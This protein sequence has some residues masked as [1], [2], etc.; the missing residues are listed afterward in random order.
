MSASLND[1]LDIA[2]AAV[3]RAGTSRPEGWLVDQILEPP[4][5]AAVPQPGR[6]P[7][8]P[9]RLTKEAAERMA[10]DAQEYD[11]RIAGGRLR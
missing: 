9:R 3:L 4:A 11:G 7:S 2:M 5:P 10:A 6:T 8:R 1:R